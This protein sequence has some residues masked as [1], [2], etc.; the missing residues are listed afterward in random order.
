MDQI[1]RE[2]ESVLLVAQRMASLNVST[3]LLGRLSSNV[4]YNN[5]SKYPG[6]RMEM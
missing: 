3:A 1:S 4:Y 5:L 6:T 2:R